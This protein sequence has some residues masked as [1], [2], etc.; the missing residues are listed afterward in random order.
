MSELTPKQMATIDALMAKDPSIT[1]ENVNGYYRSDYWFNWHLTI[2]YTIGEWEYKDSLG[3]F[4]HKLPA[5]EKVL[6]YRAYIEKKR[7]QAVTR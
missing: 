7:E 5:R 1:P 2:T 4:M 3:S 6:A